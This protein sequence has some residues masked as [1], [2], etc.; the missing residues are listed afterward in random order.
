MTIEVLPFDPADQGDVEQAYRIRVASLAA[1]APDFPAPSRRSFLTALRH[2]LPG[3]EF[4]R[5]LAR[6]G[7]VP[8]GFAVL[9]LPLLD[10]T[11][12]AEVELDVHPDHRRR[13]LG[14]AL[15]Q[16][17]VA[18][19]CDRGR[20]WLVGEAVS[21]L[22]GAPSRDPAGAG[23]A[24]AM[25]A[26]VALSEVR[27]RLE[28]PAVDWPALDRT[29]AA[30]WQRASGYSLLRWVGPTPA[31]HL[32]DIAYLNSRLNTDA[33]TGELAWE[34]E[35]LDAE[36]QAAVERALITERGRPAYGV[37]ARHDAT[38][39][40]V[41]WTQLVRAESSAWHALQQITLVDPEHRGHRLGLIIKIEN[42]RYAVAGEP[43][44]RAID[45]WNA[46]VN[47]HMISINEILGYRPIDAWEAWQ[48]PL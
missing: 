9:E 26:R 38:G 46:A 7:G 44:L 36:R 10:N 24:R 34:A 39:R 30:A 31:E 32:A 25:G 41:A 35:K 37:A 1:A 2:P 6:L 45:T 27:R 18:A 15:H 43:E 12:N 22:P 16:R 33:P 23:F 3:H 48:L 19:A 14:R 40:L 17:V 13:G 4:Q 5:F 42:L 29:V 11:G 47:D 28:V 20:K 8:A 21:G